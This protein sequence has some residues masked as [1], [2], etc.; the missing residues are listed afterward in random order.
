M[1]NL[2]KILSLMM[3]LALMI[4]C[5]MPAMADVPVTAQEDTI[6]VA[7]VSEA[8]QLDPE[9]DAVTQPDA[10]INVQCYEGLFKLNPDTGEVMPCLATSYE[11]VEDNVMRVYLRD[12][13]YFHDGSK[14]T[15]E[16]VLFNISRGVK[17]ASKEYSYGPVDYEN[18]K[19]VDD[20]TIDVATYDPY[21]ALLADMLDNGWV[22]ISKNYFENTDYA[23]FIRHPMGTGPWVFKEW[24]AG[25]SISFTRNENYWG[26]KPYFGNLVIRTI[27]DDT[28]RALALET[29]EV[30]Y[31]I[32]V[33]SSQIDYI[34]EGDMATV[35]LIPGRTLEYVTMNEAFEPFKDVRVR[36]A[37]MY[38]LDLPAMVNLAY[39]LGGSPADGVFF[40]GNVF[41]TP[42]TTTYTQDLEKAKA[43]MEE[44]GYADGFTCRL[45]A[46]DVSTRI[47]MCE[48]MKNAWAQLNV[49]AEIS[50]MDIATYYNYIQSGDYDMGLGGFVCQ[51]ND[52]DMYRHMFITGADYSSNYAQYSNPEFD[53]LAEKGRLELDNSIRQ[54]YYDQI[55]EIL[56]NDL[57]WLPICFATETYGCRNTLKGAY[58]YDNGI[59]TFD[60]VVPADAE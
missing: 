56:R 13:V 42:A 36:Q 47:T 2:T 10:I 19:V 38:A 1:K 60:K 5:A 59:P 58:L 22:M 6:T 25:D 17:S 54:G 26:E 39:G 55:Q 15:A 21:P 14:F 43:L 41:Y 11:W 32:E 53:E 9:G 18:C 40:P 29:G 20:Y 7:M 44:A 24:I 50:V 37:L 57:P 45:I 31:V 46:K 8:A 30:D 52:G 4:A 12:D 34:N 28:T 51:V 23:E 35:Q 49:N 27:T 48:M 33:V 3:V 16:D